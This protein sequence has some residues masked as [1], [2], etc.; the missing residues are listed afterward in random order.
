MESEM[1]EKHIGGGR[2]LIETCV[3][4][5]ALAWMYV[6]TVNVLGHYSEALLTYDISN[7]T[8]MFLQ[9]PR[10]PQRSDGL[11]ARIK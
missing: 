1:D 7:Q 4:I 2:S 6:A 11:D 5:V 9:L 8:M 3:L 10:P